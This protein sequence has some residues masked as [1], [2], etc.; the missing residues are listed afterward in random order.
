MNFTQMANERFG[1]LGELLSFFLT[2]KRWWMLPVITVLL[3]LGV[4]MLFAQSS[5][6]APFLYTLF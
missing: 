4:F 5:A 3:L 6:I 1:I 2:Q